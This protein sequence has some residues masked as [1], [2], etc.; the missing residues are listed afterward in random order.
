MKSFGHTADISSCIACPS[1][2][3]YIG[4]VAKLFAV[5][6]AVALI[7]VPTVMRSRQHI[8]LHDSTRLSIR[9]NWQSDAP[10]QRDLFVPDTSVADAIVPL[11]FMQQPHAPAVAPR[12]RIFDEPIVQPLF[13]NAP[14]LFRGPPALLS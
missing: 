5:A 10:P 14:D 8:E 9:L 4:A 7:V 3:R 1:E 13:D 11:A 6:I 12:A 2:S